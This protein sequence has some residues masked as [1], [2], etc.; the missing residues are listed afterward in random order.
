MAEWLVKQH[1]HCCDAL[2]LKLGCMLQ[3]LRRNCGPVQRQAAE[4]KVARQA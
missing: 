4:D 2:T 3:A 1:Q